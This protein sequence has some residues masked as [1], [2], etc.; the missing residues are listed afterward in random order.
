MISLWYCMIV[1]C[2]QHKLTSMSV[3]MAA[4]QSQYSRSMV[5]SIQ[6]SSR[7]LNMIALVPYIS[8]KSD[9]SDSDDEPE[10]NTSKKVTD[11]D[12]DGGEECD[13]SPTPPLS[14]PE[15]LEELL[16]SED[17]NNIDFLPDNTVFE[18]NIGKQLNAIVGM[19]IETS[20]IKLLTQQS[21]RKENN[22]Q[23]PI[24]GLVGNYDNMATR[25][26]S[27]YAPAS[28]NQTTD[29][30]SSSKVD[31]F[32]EVGCQGPGSFWGGGFDG[33]AFCDSLSLALR[34][35]QE[36]HTLAHLVSPR[37]TVAERLAHSPLTKAIWVQFP[38]GSLRIFTCGNRADDVLEVAAIDL[39]AGVQTTPKVVKGTGEDMLRDGIDSCDKVGLEFFE[40]VRVVAVDL[41]L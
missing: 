33:V 6:C 15:I 16:K 25:P 38:A 20:P 29:S 4:K 5:Q 19:E 41:S 28:E 40:C 10:I 3:T 35:E 11:E 24:V 12:E 36:A 18:E 27:G 1:A 37:A 32:P 21:E 2:L 9:E 14:L 22:T 17:F 31:Q 8:N 26:S 30:N 39:E 13:I 34:L 23:E 7:T